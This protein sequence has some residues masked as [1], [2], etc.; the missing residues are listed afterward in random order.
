[1]HGITCISC[2]QCNL[3]AFLHVRQPNSTEK[4]TVCGMDNGRHPKIAMYGYVHGQR[5]SYRGRPRTRW[6]DM[7]R[8]DCEVTDATMHDVIGQPGQALDRE[9]DGGD[10]YSGD[11]VAC[12]SIA[13]GPSQVLSLS[14]VFLLTKDF[15]Y[16]DLSDCYFK[17]YA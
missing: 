13:K 2:K 12:N 14:H 17:I 1:M 9:R 6:T 15:R 16:C 8:R 5:G 11:A 10:T 7:I 4:F 3:A